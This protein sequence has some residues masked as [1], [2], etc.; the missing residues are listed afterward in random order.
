MGGGH[1]MFFLKKIP[2][3]VFLVHTRT[4]FSQNDKTRKTLVLIKKQDKI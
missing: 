4:D 3:F 1:G 2:K